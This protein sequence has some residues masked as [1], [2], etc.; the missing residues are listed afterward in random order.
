MEVGDGQLEGLFP[1][2]G[3]EAGAHLVGGL[4]GEGEGE[5]ALG[6]G[7]SQPA[8]MLADPVTNELSHGECLA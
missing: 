4:Y 3:D 6:R 8:E 2:A 5:D 1:Q 7:A